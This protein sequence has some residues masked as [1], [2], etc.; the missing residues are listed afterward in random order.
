MSVEAMICLASG[1]CVGDEPFP[2]EIRLLPRRSREIATLV[3]EAKAACAND[4]VRRLSSPLANASVRS[5]LNR[6]VAK[7]ILKRQ[8]YGQEYLYTP[9]ISL[10]D[11]RTIALEKFIEDH[12]S[13]SASLAA[14]TM[15]ELLK[16]S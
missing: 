7:G 9:A 12:F 10:T 4:V 5:I 6:L 2:S 3:Y 15:V 8:L 16:V 13:G 1:E 11:S 14:A